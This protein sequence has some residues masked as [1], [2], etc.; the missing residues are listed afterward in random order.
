[1]TTTKTDSK[2]G[3]ADTPPPSDGATNKSQTTLTT[4]PQDMNA[5]L[6]SLLDVVHV[7]E[8][9]STRTAVQT[10]MDT[11]AQLTA[12]W[13]TD[14]MTDAY[15]TL[16]GP[17]QG[18]LPALDWN[19]HFRK[20]LVVCLWIRPRLGTTPLS[21][22]ALLLVPATTDVLPATASNTGTGTGT[23]SLHQA[24]ILYRLSTTAE[25]STAQGVCVT[26]GD[27]KV[28][29]DHTNTVSTVLTAYILP[30]QP[31]AAATATNKSYAS[32]VRLPC[33]F[34]LDTWQLL[35]LQH[36]HPYLKRP[37][38]S[39]SVDGL[40]QGQAELDYPIIASDAGSNANGSSG[41]GI[42]DYNAILQNIVVGGAT[43]PKLSTTS[44]SSTSPSSKQ[45]RRDDQL[46]ASELAQRQ[47][48]SA[49]NNNHE[50][51]D[52]VTMEF[53]LDVASLA[54]YTEIIPPS[55]Q[56]LCAEAGPNLSLT[57]AGHIVPTLP[58]TCC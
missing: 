16:H 7:D 9:E 31:P 54:L 4:I 5:R 27:W 46:S 8:E 15:V 38:W 35:V 28:E 45:R 20:A 42:V 33:R 56:A 55:L 47:H 25:D 26:V 51:S 41:G 6:Q 19:A 53:R 14:G 58:Q 49:A 34:Q 24:R 43:R 40:L 21:Q 1:M 18:H 13:Q 37:Y 30:Q 52:M 17:T 11:L 2:K 44:S 48:S 36:A 3:V 22:E 10:K 32:Y 23:G 50:N 39:V 12:T 29:E 57:K